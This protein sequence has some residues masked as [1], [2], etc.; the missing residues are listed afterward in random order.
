MGKS[1]LCV[2]DVKESDRMDEASSL[3]CLTPSAD[4]LGV[5]EQII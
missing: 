2:L 5:A 1:G 3:V 4:Y